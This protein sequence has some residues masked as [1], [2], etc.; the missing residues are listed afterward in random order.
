MLE[1]LNL[2]VRVINA[3][4]ILFSQ[5]KWRWAGSVEKEL[6]GGDWE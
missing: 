4:C 3:A 1:D 5:P 2:E 6:A